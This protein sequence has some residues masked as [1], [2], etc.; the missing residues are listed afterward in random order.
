MRLA[1]LATRLSVFV[2]E[3]DM[4]HHKPVHHEIVKRA[5][6]AGLAGATVLRGCEGYGAGSVV[7]TTRLLDLTEDL[8]VVVIIVD[9][10]EKIRAFLPQLDELV[11]EGMVT[12]EE[13]EVV[14]YAGRKP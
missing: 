8:P 4:W 12:L 14:H 5:R 11:A 13:V 1:G 3:D 7:H 6:D 2:G 10:D 9:T